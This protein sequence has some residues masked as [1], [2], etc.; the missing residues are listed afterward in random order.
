M[1]EMHETWV[2]S[3]GQ[4]DAL[5]DV[6]VNSSTLAWRSPWT[7]APGRLQSTGPQRVGHDRHA[8][9]YNTAW[10]SRVQ[11]SVST[12]A[13]PTASSPP[14]IQLPSITEQ[15]PLHP[16]CSCPPLLRPF[17][18]LVSSC[19]SS[20]STCL[21]LVCSC[22]FCFFLFYISPLGES[23][24]IC[25]SPSDLFHLANTFLVHPCC[26]KWQD[27]IFLYVQHS[28]VYI[29]IHHNFFLFISVGLCSLQDL[30]CPTRNQT[31]ALSSEIAES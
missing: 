7:E 31:W 12:S 26:C 6:A 16:H 1:Q 24:G 29:Y 4:E 27:S 20:V 19:L 22:I 3:L 14:R 30:S 23:Q 21:C 17:L 15:W 8:L 11:C 10:V 28:T 25:L 5:E 18:S 2:Q 13:H 9:I